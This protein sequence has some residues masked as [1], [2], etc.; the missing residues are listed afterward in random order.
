MEPEYLQR[1]KTSIRSE[2]MCTPDTFITC[3]LH[4]SPRLGAGKLQALWAYDGPQHTFCLMMVAGRGDMRLGLQDASGAQRADHDEDQP[5]LRKD[6]S[7]LWWGGAIGP[8]QAGGR[9]TDGKQDGLGNQAE[10]LCSP[11]HIAC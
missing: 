10:G 3:L 8:G 11:F 6:S 4:A 1:R 5:V 9:E 7:L 2:L